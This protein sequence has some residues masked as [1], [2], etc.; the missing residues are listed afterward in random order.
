MASYDAAA[1]KENDAFNK[2][3]AW[4]TEKLDDL[5][6]TNIA[7]AEQSLTVLKTRFSEVFFKHVRDVFGEVP[8]H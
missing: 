8:S 2:L 7:F 1:E 4:E 6:A 5:I 3:R